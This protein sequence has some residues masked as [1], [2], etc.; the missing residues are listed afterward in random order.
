[1]AGE[2]ACAVDSARPLKSFSLSLEASD[3]GAI[4]VG[5][6]Y[7]GTAFTTRRAG[8]TAK[9]L[10]SDQAQR[11]IQRAV[12]KWAKEVFVAPKRAVKAKG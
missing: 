5:N 10:N 6:F 8:I 9:D 3:N 7:N 1:M 12:I 4:L 11:R 2:V